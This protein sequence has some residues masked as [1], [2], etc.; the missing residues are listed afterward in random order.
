MNAD[1]IPSIIITTAIAS[2][3]CAGATGDCCPVNEHQSFTP[4]TAN[5]NDQFGYSISMSG[6]R[7]V[8]GAPHGDIPA[9]PTP[10]SQRWRDLDL[11]TRSRSVD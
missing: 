3:I 7:L 6:T 1:R 4:S 5:A 11:D 9:T 2:T 10:T 8:V